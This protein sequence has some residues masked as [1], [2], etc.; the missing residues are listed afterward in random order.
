MSRR[1]ARGC[2]CSHFA[3]AFL[4]DEWRQNRGTGE[5]T[6]AIGNFEEGY[7]RQFPIMLVRQE[8]RDR[9][10]RERDYRDAE[11]GS[12]SSGCS[13]GSSEHTRLPV[14]QN[15]WRGRERIDATHLNLG[16]VP[17][18]TWTTGWWVRYGHVG[19]AALSTRRALSITIGRCA[20]SRI[21]SHP[22]G[23]RATSLH[24]AAS[25]CRAFCE[26]WKVD[27]WWRTRGDRALKTRLRQQSPS[28]ASGIACG[29]SRPDIAFEVGCSAE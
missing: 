15:P 17:P 13:V 2:R 23:R 5:K 3:S 14:R 9:G 4:S 18:R 26:T 12:T 27:Q 28:A 19:R 6:F 29:R 24:P 20:P 22:S 10:V 11:V 16:L 1:S 8:G 21:G 7:V 25:S